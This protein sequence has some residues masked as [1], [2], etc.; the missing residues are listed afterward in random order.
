MTQENEQTIS[1]AL[2]RELMQD[3]QRP[4]DRGPLIAGGILLF[5][6][7]GLLGAM[8]DAKFFPP[9]QKPGS[10]AVA[11]APTP[12]NCALY[13]GQVKILE[14]QLQEAHTQVATL[15]GQIAAREG[16]LTQIR[17]QLTE[18][19]AHSTENPA[20][21]LLWNGIGSI[22]GLPPA[23][24]TLAKEATAG[25]AG[26]VQSNIARSNKAMQDARSAGQLR[27]IQTL[28][29]SCGTHDNADCV[30]SRMCEAKQNDPALRREAEGC[31]DSVDCWRAV[32]SECGH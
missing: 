8:L 27:V 32:L 19:S 14:G 21:Q 2:H 23:V 16:E 5:L 13:A 9:E 18:H 24:T 22:L 30:L 4:P 11:E 31:I 20:E 6:V 29:Q 28:M 15:Q 3:A 25:L 10:M 26:A 1:V 12:A 17:D 7:G